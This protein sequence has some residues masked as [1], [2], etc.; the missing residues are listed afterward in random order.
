[1][2]PFDY[3][4]PTDLAG[5]TR[6]AAAPRTQFIA[7]GTTLVDLM[8]LDVMTP[9]HL[10]DVNP[11][12]VTAG[13][14]DPTLATIAELPDGGMR[15]GA[16]VRMSDA[17]W[18]RRLR[19][20]YPMVSE[21]LLL[22]ASGQLRNMAT[23]GGNVL[24]RTRCPY[25]RDTGTPCNKREPGTGCPSIAGYNRTNAILGT[26][27]HCIA[28]HASDFAV[29]LAALDATVHV[30][31]PGATS[32]R[33]L[34][35]TTLHVT[36]GDHPEIETVLAPGEFITGYTLPA[37][38]WAR[39]STYRKVRD[40]ASYAFALASAAVAL[41]VD[42]G[43]VRNARIALGGVATKPWRA[44][45]AE[46]AL[47]GQPATEASFRHAADLALDGAVPYRENAFKIELAKRTLVRALTEMAA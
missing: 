23:L 24:Q 28:T 5:A 47:V 17:G 15:L 2:H 20:R 40:R 41:D 1:M 34:P 25:F 19:E 32:D 26:S 45:A 6:A 16:L 12:G 9:D 33:T 35:F 14:P 3:I 38:P 29:A 7:G 22:A 43:Q 42:A 11:L 44:A 4:V 18:D 10:V 13:Q 39:R 37:L 30:R 27:Q 21:S 8:Q 36:P 31:A 46:R